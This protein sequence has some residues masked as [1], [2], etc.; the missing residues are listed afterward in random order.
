MQTGDGSPT[1]PPSMSD[2]RVR[3]RRRVVIGTGSVIVLIAVAI[4]G[5]FLMSPRTVTRQGVTIAVAGTDLWPWGNV[6][7]V[8]AEGTLTI[9]QGC[10]VIVSRDGTQRLPIW[11]QGA[12]RSAL[13]RSSMAVSG[14]GF[15]REASATS[16][17]C[18]ATSQTV[19]P[20]GQSTW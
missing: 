10:V 15:E 6:T 4:A 13:V 11:P 14:S 5:A 12:T 2:G 19:V 8:G 3:V 7:G 17:G 16:G 20:S 18:E 9:S 1:A